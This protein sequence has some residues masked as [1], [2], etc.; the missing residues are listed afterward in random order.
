[1][2]PPLEAINWKTGPKDRIGSP[3]YPSPSETNQQCEQAQPPRPNKAVA[4][5]AGIEQRKASY[6]RWLGDN[7]VSGDQR[8]KAVPKQVHGLVI[9]HKL[10]YRAEVLRERCD[11]VIARVTLVTRLVLATL[12]VGDNPIARR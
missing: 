1:M 6:Q 7:Q 2:P 10:Y 8:T 3:Y 12:I 11:G 9:T 5:R 4:S